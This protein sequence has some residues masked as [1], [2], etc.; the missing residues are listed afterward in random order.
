MSAGAWQSAAVGVLLAASGFAQVFEK[1]VRIKAAGEC[2]KTEIGHSAPYMYDFDGDGVRDLLVGQFG[3]G[4]L[5]I[6]RNKG[7]A[8]QPDYEEVRWFKAAGEVAT[9]PAG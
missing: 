8:R 9:V 3:S 1:P 7:T 5:R 4:K 2:I 6:Y